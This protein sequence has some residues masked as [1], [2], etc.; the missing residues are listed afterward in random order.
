MIVTEH[1]YDTYRLSRKEEIKVKTIH[2]N[3]LDL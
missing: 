1:D 2:F 3:A